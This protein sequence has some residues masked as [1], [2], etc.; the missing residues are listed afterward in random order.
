MLQ[1]RL[2]R[3]VSS[4]SELRIRLIEGDLVPWHR[5]IGPKVSASQEVYGHLVALPQEEPIKT[6]LEDYTEEENA[7]AE[8]AARMHTY[9]HRIR[10][11][12]PFTR[13]VTVLCGWWRLDAVNSP[14]YED[15][16][17]TSLGKEAEEKSSEIRISDEFLGRTRTFD[18]TASTRDFGG[19]EDRGGSYNRALQLFKEEGRHATLYSTAQKRLLKEYNITTLFTKQAI[20]ATL[21]ERLQMVV[22]KD[23]KDAEQKREALFKELPTDEEHV[24][25]EEDGNA[26]N[27]VEDLQHD[28][29][30]DPV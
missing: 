20:A 10:I 3:V 7:K 15:F 4:L 21:Q 30:V 14:N 29:D 28:D 27:I 13:D 9:F 24:L 23:Q 12:H 18:M 6:L 26:E 19:L 8:I 16:R 5:L 25:S 22:E 1:A 17:K 2:K 11:Q